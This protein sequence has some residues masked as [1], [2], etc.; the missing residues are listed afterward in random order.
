MTA[1]RNRVVHA[2]FAVNWEIVWT[3]AIKDLPELRESISQLL[4]ETADD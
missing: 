4:S 1:F 3:T 2:Y